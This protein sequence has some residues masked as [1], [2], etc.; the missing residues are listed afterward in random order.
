M[1]ASISGEN[2]MPNF[3]RISEAGMEAMVFSFLGR[4]Q[5]LLFHGC[6][7]GEINVVIDTHSS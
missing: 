6:H 4:G 1:Y 2:L 7:W 5:I 3:M